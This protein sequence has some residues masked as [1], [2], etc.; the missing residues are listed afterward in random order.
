[1]PV[2]ELRV[3]VNSVVD[4]LRK[5]Q[6]QQIIS[7]YRTDLVRNQVTQSRDHLLTASQQ[8]VAGFAKLGVMEK[9]IC[10]YMHLEQLGSSQYWGDI[11]NSAKGVEVTRAEVVQLYSRVMFAVNHLPGFVQ[12]LKVES[13]S[14]DSSARAG[15]SL[16]KI[17]LVDAGE[18]AS[19]PDRV[20]RT[21]DGID[22]VYSACVSLAKKPVVD[23]SLVSIHGGSE[24]HVVFEG[25]VGGINAVREVIASMAEEIAE[26]ENPAD[27][28]PDQLVSDLPVFDDLQTLQKLGS[29]DASEAK[30]IAES[31]HEGCLLVMESG[32]MLE[33]KP[34]PEI[35]PVP[36]AKVVSLPVE[37]ATAVVTL[38]QPPPK[39][40]SVNVA[41]SPSPKSVA[42]SAQVA[43]LV[44]DVTPTVTLKQK[45]PLS[46]A[47]QAAPQAVLAQEITE[48][49]HNAKD[50]NEMTPL[51]FYE[52]Y[53]KEKNK[54]QESSEDP[55]SGM[56]KSTQLMG[57]VGG[58]EKSDALN[59]LILDLDRITG[60]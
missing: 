17:K 29:F 40:V 33:P 36:E 42:A 6:I 11:L 3:A 53:L 15:Y 1:M 2:S 22:M 4:L 32:V 30:D 41:P 14:S 25:D 52:Q 50:P 51:E 18:R 19:D 54:M 38:Q 21:I 31:M 47:V 57:A 10:S 16:L 43:A 34:K 24:K 5:T 23:L 28:D 9:R 12:M 27:F 58:G 56:D 44:S 55:M 59:D 49:S 26:I 8:L 39:E 35:K 37:R 13:L 7:H 46:V 45:P 48:Q 60:K 20:S